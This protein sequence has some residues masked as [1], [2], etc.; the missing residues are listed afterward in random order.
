[1]H[2]PLPHNICRGGRNLLNLHLFEQDWQSAKCEIDC[3]PHETRMWSS[4]PGFFDG[5][6]ESHVLPI[7]I[8]CSLHAPLEVIQS[9]V[10]VYPGCLSVKESSFQRLP[11]HV[12]CQF[13]ASADVIDYLAREFAAGTSEP[14]VL[15][16]FPIHYACSNGAPL[17]VVAALLRANPS[18]TLGA[19]INGWLPLHVAIHFG[20]STEAIRELVRVCPMA[21]TMKT[22]KN[23]TALTLAEHVSTT[24]RKEVIRILSGAKNVDKHHP[25]T[26]LVAARDVAS[27][28]NWYPGIQSHKILVDH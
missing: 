12:A 26:Y 13:S 6:H 2:L 19:D 23:S 17:A 21:V 4:Q 7:H 10:E 25:T 8:A 22:K 3:H 9:I 27:I 28:E 1:M 14:D 16:R 5:Q 11:L 18:S 24:N 20:A 15:G